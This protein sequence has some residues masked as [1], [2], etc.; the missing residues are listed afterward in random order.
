MLAKHYQT[1]W[2][3]EFARKYLDEN[4]LKY[5]FDD[6]EKIAQGQ[7][8]SMLLAEK[9]KQGLLFFD[10]E[11]IVIKIWSEV[12]FKKCPYFIEEMLPRQNFDLYLLCYPDLPWKYDAMRENPENRELLFELYE[13]ELKK[14]NFNYRI[15]KGT[16][17]ERLQNA[18]T[19]V[20]EERI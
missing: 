10:T 16:E 6:L 11:L 19:F 1:I 12:V 20:E 3:Q 5:T 18:I 8:K 13:I 7:V 2:V 17:T 9:T 14:Q 4:G 15:V